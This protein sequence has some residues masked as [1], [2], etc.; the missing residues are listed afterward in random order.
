MKKPFLTMLAAVGLP[1]CGLSGL[2]AGP[3]I[4]WSVMHPVA[5]DVGYMRRVVEKA[6]EYGHVDS[7]ELCGLEQIGINGLSLFEPYPHAHAAA[8]RA[9]VERTR[10]DL[11]AICEI[12][13]TAGKPVYFWHR[14]NLVPKGIFEDVPAL[15]D[16]D[17]EFDLLGEAYEKYLRYKI[18]DAFRNCPGL[19]GLVLTLT[20]CEYSVIH[21]SNQERY[22][23]ETCV[24]RVVGIF[25]DELN[26]RGKRLVLRS[27]GDGEDYVKI[28]RGALAAAKTAGVF[29]I[30]TKVTEADFVPFLPRNQYLKRDLPLTLGAEC[31]ALGEFLG[32][33]WLPAAQVARIREYVDSAREEGASRYAIRIDRKGFPIFDTAHEVNLYAYM[34]FI[35]DPRATAE[36][37]LREYAA[38]RFGRAA[39]GMIP[40]LRD[41]LELVRNVNYVASNLTFHAFPVAPNLKYVKAGGIFALFRENESLAALKDIWSI[42]YRMRT[43]DHARIL[44]E[45]D[46]GLELA[47]RGLATVERLKDD[48][49][50]EEYARQHRAFANAVTLAKA[51]RAY[52]RCVV[53]YFEDMAARQD[54]PARLAAA[55][56]AAQ[57]TIAALKGGEMDAPYLNGIGFF[58]RE[59]LREYRLERAAR[60]KFEARKDVYDF[61]I[62]GGIY[63][64]I[65]VGRLMHA[66]YPET[67][68]DRIVRHVGN[69]TFPIGR[70]TVRLNAPA[71]ARID[72][73]L[74]PDGAPACDVRK[75]WADGTW[76]VSIGKTGADYPAVLSVA[77]VRGAADSGTVK[78]A[79]FE[80][81]VSCGLGV[82]IAG[83]DGDDV[84][85]GKLD[86][87][88][89]CG[90]CLDDGREKALILSFDLL[91]L[92]GD[93]I[94]SYRRFAAEKLGLRE[95][96]VLVSCT[97]THGG[98]HTRAYERNRGEDD[99]YVLPDDPGHPDV[100]YVKELDERVRQAIAGFADRA[101][102]KVCR[103]G[104]F[105][106]QVD[107]NRNRRYTTADNCASFI[108][109]RR[110]LHGIATGTADKELGTVVLLDARTGAPLYV[111]GNYAAHPLASHAPGQGGLRITSDYPGFYRRYVESETG[112]KAMFVQGAAGDLVPKDD[113]LG[114]AA[115]RRTGENLA[116]ASLAAIIDI[117]R[118]AGRFVLAKPRLG[119]EIRRFES[120]VRPV[121]REVLKK[122]VLT[123]E[124]QCLSVGDIAF[125]A[126]PGEPVC[127]LGLEIKWHSPFRR[128]FVAYG[129][130]GNCGY[131]SP[132][133]FMAAGAYEPQ[134][135]QFASRDTLKLV[136][137]A[138]DAL[139]T[140]RSRTFPEDDAIAG[141]YPDNQNLPLVNLP[142]GVKKSKWRK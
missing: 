108:A 84:A 131:V 118:N 114:V 21:N 68:A 125:V 56:S 8:D 96:A 67:K 94:R 93:T 124:V 87:L 117:T 37:V 141:G 115:A 42:L 7:F 11:N 43:P 58:C 127:E 83:Y 139:F 103:V 82:G 92:D 109:H 132:E 70:I 86:D 17:G 65:R 107:E 3:E 10:A 111:I 98:P 48:L 97:H 55:S 45:K 134:Y 99:E 32:A 19:D 79:W 105:S 52:T 130:I 23:S 16:A 50:A 138:R 126:L 128:T 75:E 15:L 135:Q 120:P 1:L 20:E 110:T 66:A 102:W 22:P 90:L 51:M 137:T 140:V 121:W 74:D 76:T 29:E 64:D 27:F 2:A 53:A 71:D 14:E 26:R 85:T 101:D 54:A 91:F 95:E 46:R 119:A 12:A 112:A 123:L 59:L 133:N 18:G 104:C 25:A 6:K 57:E 73:A 31:D 81:D 33:G 38:R 4:S 35:R 122:D 36:D 142:G 24:S 39:E 63:D 28:R 9:F 5:F 72:V 69:P 60:A 30:E 49:P 116:M 40:V 100:K 41:E 47:E 44:A 129:G 61:V 62:A 78:A 13:H 80:A 77:A 106:A 89:L 88:K 34:R 113:E 136:E